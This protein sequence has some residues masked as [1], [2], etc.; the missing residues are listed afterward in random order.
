MTVL[1]L[2]WHMHAANI[3]CTL[4]MGQPLSWEEKNAFHLIRET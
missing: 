2:G 4:I 3:Y 1:S